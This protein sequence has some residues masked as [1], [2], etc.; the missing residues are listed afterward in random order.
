MEDLLRARIPGLDVQPIGAGRF[1]VRVRGRAELATAQPVVVIDGMRYRQGGV[2]MLLSLTPAEVRRIEVLKDA[3]S[4]ADARAGP[5]G[6][7]VVTTW[8]H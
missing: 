2:D 8:R 6:V 4:I 1:T 3:A 5:S 7:I